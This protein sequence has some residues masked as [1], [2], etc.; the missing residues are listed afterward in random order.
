[1]KWKSGFTLIEL[2][3]VVA[4][5][6]VLIAML[7]PALG[8]ARNQAK[9]VACMSQMNQSGLAMIMYSND[10]NQF[11]PLYYSWQIGEEKSWAGFLN[12]KATRLQINTGAP[13]YLENPDTAVCPGMDPIKFNVSLWYSIYG[14]DYDTYTSD[15]PLKVDT[16]WT[17]YYR[18]LARLG[19]PGNLV[20]LLDSTAGPTT[21]Y[22]QKQ[23]MIARVSIPQGSQSYG[24]HLRHNN[25]TNVF[26][27][28]GHIE[29]CDK[30]MLKK[31]TSYT[32]GYMQN[33]NFVVF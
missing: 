9:A 20:L 2:L 13:R 24:V 1:M 26:F 23:F 32:S 28:D 30:A 16:N 33:F 17:R 15:L 21:G 22:S 29:A 3:V 19:T 12:W 14:T 6:A 31:K 4:I 11:V 8:A 7:L 27:G 25:K 5:I 10:N 18:N